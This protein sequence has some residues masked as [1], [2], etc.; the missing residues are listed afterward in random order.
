MGLFLHYPYLHIS[1]QN[2][3]VSGGCVAG[4]ER[5]GEER[6]MCLA[7]GSLEVAMCKL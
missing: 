1:V 6:D 7:Y 4:E 2:Y 3:H 5:R